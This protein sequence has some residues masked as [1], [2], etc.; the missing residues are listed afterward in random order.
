MWVLPFHGSHGGLLLDSFGRTV[1]LPFWFILLVLLAELQ[2]RLPVERLFELLVLPFWSLSFL[3]SVVRTAF[4]L[5][6]PA[7][8]LAFRLLLAL[9][10]L[11]FW[12]PP[13]TLVRPAGQDG[14]DL[15]LQRVHGLR[16]LPVV[17]VVWIGAGLP[18]LFLR[19]DQSPGRVYIFIASGIPPSERWRLLL[20]TS[21]GLKGAVLL[22][23]LADTVALTPLVALTVPVRRVF[24]TAPWRPG[25]LWRADIGTPLL[26][27][28]RSVMAAGARTVLIQ[29]AGFLQRAMV[30]LPVLVQRVCLVAAFPPRGFRVWSAARRR[31][32]VIPITWP[33]PAV[34]SA[35]WM[36]VW[37]AVRPAPGGAAGWG[38]WFLGG[39]VVFRP[40]RQRLGRGRHLRLVRGG[41]VR[42]RPRGGSVSRYLSFDFLNVDVGGLPGLLTRFPAGGWRAVTQRDHR[43][44]LRRRGCRESQERSHGVVWRFIWLL[45]S[46][47]RCSLARFLLSWGSGQ[48]PLSRW[49]P[50]FVPGSRPWPGPRSWVG[51]RLRFGQGQRMTPRPG[52]AS[53]SWV[54]PC[55]SSG[56]GMTGRVW[57][58]VGPGVSERQRGAAPPLDRWLIPIWGMT[59][60]RAGSS[61][62]SL[63]GQRPFALWPVIALSFDLGALL[64]AVFMFFGLLLVFGFLLLLLLLLLA[65]AGPLWA[66]VRRVFRG[67]GPRRVTSVIPSAWRVFI[68]SVKPKD[69]WSENNRIQRDIFSEFWKATCPLC[70]ISPGLGAGRPWFFSSP[71]SSAAAFHCRHAPPP[72]P[73]V[74][75]IGWGC[76]S[77]ARQIKLFTALLFSNHPSYFISI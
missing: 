17:P 1:P 8:V 22:S 35:P 39:S 31:P 76:D 6:P 48:I 13:G 34:A 21:A 61:R 20:H 26:W 74:T 51:V 57:S 44:A 68:Q 5:A 15:L 50:R 54:W 43:D 75:W 3:F 2:R 32:A 30:V 16:H 38:P 10:L 12:R 47:V 60:W 58:G 66:A 18:L 11:G 69:A 70:S 71:L 7:L 55:P 64:L 49:R 77:A 25:P 41:A 65:R 27:P 46:A 73:S 9:M 67:A 24:E 53:G 59:G 72:R 63:W 4:V 62:F 45:D 33:G 37:A 23:D 52:M 56:S 29:I 19:Y 42:R 40:P 36:A 14:R 28:G